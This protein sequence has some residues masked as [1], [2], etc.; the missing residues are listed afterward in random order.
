M[1]YHSVLYE[2]TPHHSLSCL[3]EV[4]S[5]FYIYYITKLLKSQNYIGTEQAR[6]G[7]LS[8]K[9]LSKTLFPALQQVVF[10]VCYYLVHGWYDGFLPFERTFAF[11]FFRFR[12]ICVFCFLKLFPINSQLLQSLRNC[13][14]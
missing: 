5:F 1:C 7:V 12:N 13:L 3:L 4:F 2:N 10:V 9:M 8:L 14:F 6:C 11:G